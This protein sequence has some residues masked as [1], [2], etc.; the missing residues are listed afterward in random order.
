ML[1]GGDMAVI[2]RETSLLRRADVDG[3][4]KIDETDDIMALEKYTNK[5]N[6]N[7]KKNVYYYV[8]TD[9]FQFGTVLGWV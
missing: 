8:M 7:V 3:L 9:D 1:R 6:K 2:G 4:K 5:N